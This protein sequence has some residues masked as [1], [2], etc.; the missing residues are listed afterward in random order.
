MSWRRREGN[1]DSLARAD[2]APRRRLLP[3]PDVGTSTPSP[4]RHDRAITL[5][6]STDMLFIAAG[7]YPPLSEHGQAN[8][9]DDSLLLLALRKER[10]PQQQS[11]PCASISK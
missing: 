2:L 3:H 6:L 7:V 9:F 8:S 1:T 4:V 5:H 11:W 10:Q